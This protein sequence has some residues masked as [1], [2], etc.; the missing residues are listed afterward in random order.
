MWCEHSKTNMAK[1]PPTIS[2]SLGHNHPEICK[3]IDYE[4]NN[5]DPLS[6]WPKATN[7]SGGNAQTVLI[8]I[9]KHQLREGLL[10]EDVH[11]AQSLPRESP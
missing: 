1:G 6:L 5:I 7:E 11:F 4:K 8:T 10:A 2:E 9:G 3:E